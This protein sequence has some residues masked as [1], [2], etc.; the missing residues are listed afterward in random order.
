MIPQSQGEKY[1][2]LS[3]VAL[4]NYDRNW[5]LGPLKALALKSIFY[6]QIFH[7]SPENKIKAL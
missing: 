3:D 7:K 2:I 5:L 1:P 6:S 4:L